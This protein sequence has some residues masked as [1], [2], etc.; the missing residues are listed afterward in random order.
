MAER[1]QEPC[2]VACEP[3]KT[4]SAGGNGFYVL[5]PRP[6]DFAPQQAVL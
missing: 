4:I 2:N 6:I 1:S 3:S 5:P